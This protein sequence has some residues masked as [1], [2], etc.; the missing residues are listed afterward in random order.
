[1]CR[2]RCLYRAEVCHR[3]HSRGKRGGRIYPSVCTARTESAD[4]PSSGQVP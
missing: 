1:M 4:R 3:R 2:R